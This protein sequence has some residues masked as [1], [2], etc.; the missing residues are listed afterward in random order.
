MQGL[1]LLSDG[2]WAAV[3]FGVL[4]A[5]IIVIGCATGVHSSV[6]S[7]AVRRCLRSLSLFV[8]FWGDFCERVCNQVSGRE[9]GRAGKELCCNLFVSQKSPKPYHSDHAAPVPAFISIRSR[10]EYNLAFKIFCLTLSFWLI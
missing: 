10:L 8:G 4:V 6:C 1:R 2:S 5:L 9:G 3:S 7:V